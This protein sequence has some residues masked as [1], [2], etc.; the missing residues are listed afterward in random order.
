MFPWSVSATAR[1]PSSFAFCTSPFA[2]SFFVFLSETLAMRV[3]PSS[4]EYCECTCRCTK[5]GASP[6]EPAA[7]A[8]SRSASG[9]LSAGFA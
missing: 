2:R 5:S 9:A 4:I 1:M 3:A 7:G 6:P 8:S